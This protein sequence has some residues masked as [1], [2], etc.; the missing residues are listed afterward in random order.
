MIF[1]PK[2][3]LILVIKNNHILYRWRLILAGIGN[4]YLFNDDCGAFTCGS[5]TFFMIYL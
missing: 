3:C 4:Y 5:I 1:L 2:E